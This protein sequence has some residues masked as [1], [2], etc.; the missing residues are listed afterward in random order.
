M[1]A[2]T[3]LAELSMHCRERRCSGLFIVVWLGKS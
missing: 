1:A 2:A 3:V